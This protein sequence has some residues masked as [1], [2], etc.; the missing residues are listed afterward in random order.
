MNKLLKSI[1]G[2]CNE[3]TKI[4]LNYKKYISAF[5]LLL[6]ILVLLILPKSLATLTAIK[7]VEFKSNNFDYEAAEP[8]AWKVT[9]SASW[10]GRGLAEITFDVNTILKPKYKHRDVLFVL[11][12]SASMEGARINKVKEDTVDLLGKLMA[13]GENKAALITFSDTSS[14]VSNF[15]NDMASLIDYVNGLTLGENTNYYRALLNVESVLKT[16]TSEKGRGCIVLFLTDGWPNRNTPSEVGQYNLIKKQFPYALINGIQ[17]EMG[18]T[19]LEQ[20]ERVTDVQYVAKI[21]TLHNV[22]ETASEVIDVYKNF[23]ITDYIDDRYFTLENKS[24]IT[25]DMGSVSFDKAQQKITWSLGTPNSGFTAKMKIKVKLK[26]EYIGEGGIYPTNKKTDISNELGD[27]PEEISSTDT[28]VLADNYKVIYDK[29]APESCEVTNFPITK[30]HSVN[31]IVDISQNIPKCEGYQFKKWQITTDGVNRPGDDYFIMPESDV[32]I[33]AIWSKLNIKKT[34]NGNIYTAPIML[35][36]MMANKAVLDNTKSEFV[37]ASSG[38]NFANGA[39]DTNG[40]GIYEIASTRYQTYPI[41]YY[42]GQ[43]N[44]NAKFAGFCWKIVRTTDTGGVKIIYNGIPDEKGK[45][46]DG[47]DIFVAESEYNI[48]TGGDKTL[49]GYMYSSGSNISTNTYSSI[50]KQEVDKWYENNLKDYSSMLE[51]TVY[52]NDRSVYS[53]ENTGANM[54]GVRTKFNG[55]NRLYTQNITL[56]CKNSSDRFTVS[57]TKGN[58]ALT[59]PIALLTLDEESY[60]GNSNSYLQSEKSWWTMTPSDHSTRWGIMMVTGSPTGTSWSSINDSTATYKHTNGVRPV[61][62]LAPMAMSKTGDGSPE[63]PYVVFVRDESDKYT[64][65]IDESQGVSADQTRAWE[66]DKVKLTPTSSEHTIIS[67]KVNGK[68]VEGD[69]FVMPD[70]DVTITDVEL[71][72]SAIIE[73]VHNPYPNGVNDT[74]EKTFEGATSLTVQLEYQTENTNYDWIYLYDSA[75]TQYGKYGGNTLKTETITIPGDYVKIVFRTDS[76][77]NNYYGYKAT[78]IPNYD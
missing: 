51:D 38:I 42:R 41:Y 17:Y 13:D 26:E 3:L 55:Y 44:N 56:T 53:T 77:G 19:I 69:T 68:V 50:V 29:N 10:V 8:S 40:K 49:I 32:E 65:N 6:L 22:L 67:F 46:G 52:C 25:V 12:N 64:V 11:D 27:F 39:S 48:T 70:D 59:Y 34:M 54:S 21:N 66:G 33:K 62:S 28:P 72:I 18:D 7:S 61:V 76:S 58:G 71:F 24:D 47:R 45:C 43:V 9:K 4:F 15:T 16:Y 14:I 63:N 74:K 5:L 36:E 20:L 78:I 37:T 23:N 75:N 2:F 30:N 73:S 35:Y 57:N 60:A 1:Q 31:D